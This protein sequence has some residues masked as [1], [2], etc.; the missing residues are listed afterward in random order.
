MAS[1]A[2]LSFDFEDSD[3]SVDE[4][5]ASEA[6]QGAAPRAIASL[7]NLGPDHTLATPKYDDLE[8]LMRDLNDY[9]AEAL[10]SGVK[11]RTTNHIKDF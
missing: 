11:A 8:A 3:N 1:T 9:A 4:F 10:I 2:L 7:S 6:P 5:E